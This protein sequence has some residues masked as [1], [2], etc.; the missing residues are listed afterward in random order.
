MIAIIPAIVASIRSRLLR[1]SP[2]PDLEL[3]DTP[4]FIDQKTVDVL[5]PWLVDDVA[6]ELTCEG[7]ELSDR[8]ENAVV[9]EMRKALKPWILGNGSAAS[10]S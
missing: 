3:P 8:R 5:V 6:W 10:Y 1:Q 9:G 7:F 4:L 2:L